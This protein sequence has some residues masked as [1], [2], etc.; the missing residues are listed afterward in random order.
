M[1]F[2]NLLGF[3]I[4]ILNPYGK[5]DFNSYLDINEIKLDTIKKKVNKV[6][7]SRIRPISIL[8]GVL[9]IIYFVSISSFVNLIIKY[10]KEEISGSFCGGVGLIIIFSC[11][12]ITFV[13]FDYRN[14]I[15]QVLFKVS[16]SVMIGI[17]LIALIGFDIMHSEKYQLIEGEYEKSKADIKNEYNI[18]IIDKKEHYVGVGNKGYLNSNTGDLYLIVTSPAENEENY[19]VKIFYKKQTIVGGNND[20]TVTIYPFKYKRIF[21]TDLTLPQGEYIFDC[22]FTFSQGIFK[23][24]IILKR[25]IPIT[26][27][28]DEEFD[29]LL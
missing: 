10:A 7:K 16:I 18:E 11:I 28:S 22:E 15:N 3:D 23:D 20:N 5:N 2:F 26:S 25:T 9:S 24:D 12:A 29:K 1:F 14:K 27:I 4:V 13:C 19:S 6:K 21:K 17:G 8:N